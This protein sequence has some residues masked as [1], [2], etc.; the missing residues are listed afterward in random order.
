MELC[1][2]ARGP[3]GRAAGTLGEGVPGPGLAVQRSSNRQDPGSAHPGT[4][5]AGAALSPTASAT[6]G[7]ETKG[8]PEKEPARGPAAEQGLG[9]F[10][11]LLLP[12]QSASKAGPGGRGS[13]WQGWVHPSQKPRAELRCGETARVLPPHGALGS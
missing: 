12:V 11:G 3:D 6:V 2:T 10:L 13:P 5:G 8:S 1:H 7:D 9:A 4:P